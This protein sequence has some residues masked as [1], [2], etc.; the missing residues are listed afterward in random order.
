MA[1]WN[2]LQGSFNQVAQA[3]MAG[4]GMADPSSRKAADTTAQ[5]G[6]KSSSRSKPRSQT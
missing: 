2:M 6:D 5:N 4:A 3:A 1:W